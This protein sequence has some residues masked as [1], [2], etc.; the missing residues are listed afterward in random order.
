MQASDFPPLRSAIGAPLWLQLKH[1]LRDLATFHLKPG[2]RIPSETEIGDHYGLSRITVRQA[3]TSLVDEGLLHKRQGRGTF[4]LAPRLAENLVD[5]SHFL[6]SGF[7]AAPGEEVVVFSAESAPAPDW[8]AAKLG[9]APGDDVYK[10]RKVLTPSGEDRA[11][12]R[13]TFVPAALA[14]NLLDLDLARPM[15]AIL[16]DSFGLEAVSADEIIEF[17]I[18][19][20]FRA[21][22]LGI[23]IG[24]PL[25]LVERIAYLASGQ[26]IDCSRA[27]YKAERFRF[28]H[29]LTRSDKAAGSGQPL[30]ASRASSVIV[31]ALDAVST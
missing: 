8:L 21:G 12:F 11:A 22:M 27:Y 23:E 10:V 28:E 24:Q 31:M 15:H 18:A 14:P 29:R 13:T 4:V 5:P 19:D 1:A 30:A 7:D 26:A 6:Q 9:L 20:E 25:I 2:D 16:E 3:V 17:I